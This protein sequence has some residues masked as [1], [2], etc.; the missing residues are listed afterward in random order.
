MTRGNCPEP[1]FLK[2][3][4]TICNRSQTE[5]RFFKLQFTQSNLISPINSKTRA[6]T[7]GINSSLAAFF[8]EFLLGQSLLTSVFHTQ[9]APL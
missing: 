4:N 7:G 6:Q 3:I 9:I 1:H 2:K 5:S 8:F